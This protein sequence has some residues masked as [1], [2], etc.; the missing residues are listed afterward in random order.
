MP[1]TGPA[2]NYIGWLLVT[3][4]NSQFKILQ[5][6]LQISNLFIT[7]HRESLFR[8]SLS[9]GLELVNQI[10]L[11]SLA[12]VYFFEDTSLTFAEHHRS[13]VLVLF[14]RSLSNLLIY[15][16]LSFDLIIF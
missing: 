16:G 14:V 4:Y 8:K 7:E 6:Y 15:L 9:F 13:Q 12:V 11:A 2:R 1:E 3:Q 5:R 10:L